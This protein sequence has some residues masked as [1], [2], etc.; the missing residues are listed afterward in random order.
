[1]PNSLQDFHD[2][3]LFVLEA[4]T[5]PLRLLRD[6]PQKARL[7]SKKRTHCNAATQKSKICTDRPELAL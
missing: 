2:L 1:V 3:C 4:P 5:H 7:K 6:L